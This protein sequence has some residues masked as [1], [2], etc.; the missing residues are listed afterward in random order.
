MLVV[1]I[2]IF[3]I[4]VTIIYGFIVKALVS[5]EDLSTKMNM[6]LHNK[7]PKYFWAFVVLLFIDIIGI[8]CSAF[9]FLFLR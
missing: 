4:I 1:K 3:L 5:Q 8:I 2:T 6:A 7:Y 9:W